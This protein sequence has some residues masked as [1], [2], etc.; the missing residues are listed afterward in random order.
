MIPEEFK[1]DLPVRHCEALERFHL[2]IHMPLGT[3]MLGDDSNRLQN[4]A[5]SVGFSVDYG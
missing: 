3:F 2:A 1:D 4:V 5:I